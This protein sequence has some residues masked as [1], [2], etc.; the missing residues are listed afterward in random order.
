MEENSEPTAGGTI[1]ATITGL[2]MLSEALTNFQE[3]M[4]RMGASLERLGEE[5]LAMVTR[6]A[7]LEMAVAELQEATGRPPN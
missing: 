3:S 4:E 5:G 1:R 2:R 6:I 7:M